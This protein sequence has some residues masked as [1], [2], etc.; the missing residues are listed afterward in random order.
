[1]RGLIAATLIPLA[2]AVA[3]G[4]EKQPAKPSE[5]APA[6]LT[7]CVSAKPDTTGAYTLTQGTGGRFRLIGKSMRD[8]AGKQVEIVSGNGKG[9][10]IRGGLTPSTNV[11]AQAGHIDS[12]QAAIANQPGA[13]T[14]KSDAD[15]PELRVNRVRE[16]SGT[17]K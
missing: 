3:A 6:T 4:Q 16:V 14:G 1:M 13:N 8:F 5:T 2:V 15:L 17:C 11:A 10:S 7:G 12:A 9:L